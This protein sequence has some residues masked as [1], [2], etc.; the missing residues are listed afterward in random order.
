[1]VKFFLA[2][3]LAVASANECGTCWE[4]DD[5]GQC[6]PQAGL[7]TT[8]CGSNS[9]QVSIDACL[10]EGTHDYADAF[11]GTDASGGCGLTNTDGTLTLEHGLEECGTSM[12][13][14]EENQTIVF[15]VS[16]IYDP[17]NSQNRVLQG[18]LRFH[19]FRIN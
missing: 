10:L 11:V 15:T 5:A 17:Y 6:V 2:T 12:S 18:K 13:Y 3:G 19:F 4:A 1:M 14:D 7:V 9:I 16:P 8:T